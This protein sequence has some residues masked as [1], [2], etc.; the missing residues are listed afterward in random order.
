ME[1]TSRLSHEWVLLGDTGNK[2]RLTLWQCN[3]C[4]GCVTNEGDVAPSPD[5]LIP[6]F[7]IM[8]GRDSQM[9]TCLEQSIWNILES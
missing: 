9:M 4:H 7:S 3:K 2:K 8:P 1:N 6:Y 5:A